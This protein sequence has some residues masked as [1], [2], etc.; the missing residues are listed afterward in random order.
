MPDSESRVERVLRKV[1]EAID[2]Q[3]QAMR[4]QAE[5]M[6]ELAASN[7]QLADAIG[8]DQRQAEDVDPADAD[9]SVRDDLL[10]GERSYPVQ[11]YRSEWLPPDLDE[12]GHL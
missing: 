7:R 3:T 6:R 4:E 11:G 10:M 9:L 2:Q 5:G 8:R 12:P 1:V